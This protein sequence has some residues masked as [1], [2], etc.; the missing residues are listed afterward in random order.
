[1]K[2]QN[3]R[4]KVEKTSQWTC[5]WQTK[6][7]QGQ[8]VKEGEKGINIHGKQNRMHNCWIILRL[9]QGK[10]TTIVADGRW[11]KSVSNN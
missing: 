5:L 4:M 7:T 8:Y 1:M 6:Q 2:V 10:Q 9:W 3:P 11:T